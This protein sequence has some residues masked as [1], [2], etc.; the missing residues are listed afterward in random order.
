MTKDIFVK[1]IN[2]NEAVSEQIQKASEAAGYLWQREW[3]EANGGNISINL[4][5][6]I[7]AIPSD[8][9][10]FNYVELDFIPSQA[11]GMSF[12]VTGTGE[13][14]RN[15]HTPEK[16]ACIVH[17][18]NNC[19]GYYILW[20]ANN[21]ED[22]RPTCEMI[23][24]VKMHL[25][26]LE[27]N[28]PCRAI[29]HTHPIELICLSHHPELTKDEEKLNKLIW[30]MI[31]E[32][33]LFLKRGIGLASYST[34]ASNELAEKTVNSLA[35]RD[36][37]LWLKHGAIAAGKDT[38]EAFDYIDVA[39][40]G[41]KVYLQCLASGFTPTGLSDSELTNLENDFNL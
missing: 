33:R 25:N 14:L 31:P 37:A 40:K 32:V 34:P 39:N 18:D 2:I 35:K 19:N 27:N 1:T 41:A 38:L 13:R 17:Y 22:F 4:T 30:S 10:D 21:S 36:V 3:A 5:E 11:A 8:L 28:S 26:L 24:H 9:T 23:S 6:I 29:V 16:S 12:F 20:G 15:L 7:D